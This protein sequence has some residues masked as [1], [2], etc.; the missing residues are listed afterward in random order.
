M[1]MTVLPSISSS[2]WSWIAASTS[3]SS[4]E[5]ASSSTRIGASFEHHAR[6]GDALALA[7]G[8]LHAALADMGVVAAA[9]MPVFE[10]DDEI[11]RLGALRGVARSGLGRIGPAVADVVADRAVQQRGVL[12]H[13]RDLAAQALLRHLGDVL[14]VDQ[15]AALG[16]VV[17][18]AA[19]G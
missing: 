19:A 14:A 3:E 18:S 2:S 10:L 6:H 1:A 17:E 13:H 9:A 8:K 4:A 5:V 16:R 12:R 15:D 11:V 7:A